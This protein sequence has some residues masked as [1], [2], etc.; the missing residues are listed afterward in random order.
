[1]GIFHFTL[2]FDIFSYDK[3]SLSLFIGTNRFQ[4]L[5]HPEAIVKPN[6]DFYRVRGIVYGPVLLSLLHSTLRLTMLDFDDSDATKKMAHDTE[7]HSHAIILRVL[8]LV[9]L[10]I[11]FHSEVVDSNQDTFPMEA[12][13]LHGRNFF[14][15][16]FRA[17]TGE[18]AGGNAFPL[19]HALSLLWKSDHILKGALEL[20]S[21]LGWILKQLSELSVQ[22]KEFL[23][24]QN[25]FLSDSSTCDE[26]AAQKDSPDASKKLLA[27]KK[28]MASMQ[29]NAKAFAAFAIDLDSD[30]DS[31]L[32]QDT[33]ADTEAGKRTSDNMELSGG[34]KKVGYVKNDT[35]GITME[36]EECIICKGRG[37]DTDCLSYLCFLQPSQ[38]L[39]NLTNCESN[40]SIPQMNHA[41]RVVSSDCSVYKSKGENSALLSL[42]NYGTHVVVTERVGRWVHISVPTRGW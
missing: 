38:V 23:E 19:L 29:A 21:A 42:L 8:Y 14:N 1:M 7:K 39:K 26:K 27:Q 3:K 25:I 5:F 41:Y 17:P 40:A 2:Q 31:E 4:P 20:K 15:E 37:T 13:S 9:T 35:L 28:A 34:E 32:E 6:Y 36:D 11:Y 16:E 12:D 24:S 22:A 33:I 18:S 10:Q 30:D